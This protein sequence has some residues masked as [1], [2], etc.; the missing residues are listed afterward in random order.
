MG[1]LKEASALFILGSKE[2][3]K[4][5]QVATQ[6][7]IEGA[8]NLMQVC[9]LNTC[10]LVAQSKCHNQFFSPYMHPFSEVDSLRKQLV[11]YRN[12][13]NL[14]VRLCVCVCV[15]I[16]VESGKKS[17]EFMHSNKKTL[18]YFRVHSDAWKWWKWSSC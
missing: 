3:F 13:F 15:V 4:L 11:F 14:I 10:C 2:R 12:H 7:I 8:T 16:T 5:T 18:R 9:F 1:R 6:G 17:K